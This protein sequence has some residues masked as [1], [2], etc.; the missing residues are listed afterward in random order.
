[1][2]RASSRTTK[3]VVL[4]ECL[5]RVVML[6]AGGFC[7]AGYPRPYLSLRT[8]W[9]IC[10]EEGSATQGPREAQVATRSLTVGM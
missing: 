5:M 1:M 6:G 3:L 2:L 7:I 9:P 8:S 10:F 4:V